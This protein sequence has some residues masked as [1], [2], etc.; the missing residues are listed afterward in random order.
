[1]QG[2]FRNDFDL[3]R[4]PFDRQVLRLPFFNA[5]AANDRTSM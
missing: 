2:E 4:F 1:V 3:R 5:R